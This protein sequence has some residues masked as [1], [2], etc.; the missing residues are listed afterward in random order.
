MLV[1]S[2]RASTFVMHTSPERLTVGA[3]HRDE[4]LVAFEAARQAGAVPAPNAPVLPWTN[5]ATGTAGRTYW[6]YFLP[7]GRTG[8]YGPI[9]AKSGHYRRYSAGALRDLVETAGFTVSYLGH[10]DRL[11]IAPYWVNYRL[12]NKSGI[13][14]GSLWAFDR[15]FVPAMRAS[16]RF[17]RRVPAGKNIV[18]VATRR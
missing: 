17:L 12:L 16:E 11:G 7:L 14:G 4:F 13:S 2:L 6:R 9:D 8:D 10:V 1:R 15:L 5:D 3:T 18:C